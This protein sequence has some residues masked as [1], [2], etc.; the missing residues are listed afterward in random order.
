[1][2]RMGS[3]CVWGAVLACLAGSASA[4]TWGSLEV[5]DPI[6]PGATCAVSSPAS[7]G[8]YIYHW[9][10]KYEQVFWPLTDRQG[11]WFC[12][13]SG[14]TSFLHDFDDLEPEQVLR[15]RQFLS[16]H[17]QP[18]EGEIELPRLLDLLE[19]IYRLRNKGAEFDTRL[20]RVLAYWNET[21]M[22]NQLKADGYRR[23]ALAAMENALQSKL[24]PQRRWEYLLV[25]A[26]YR[27][28]FGDAAVAQGMLNILGN[29][30]K[31]NEDEELKDYADYLQALI[32][33]LDHIKPGGAFIPHEQ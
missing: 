21:E 4:T 10:S 1:M 28:E 33:D 31:A 14:F 30:L 3:G 25:S 2:G 16:V 17:Y 15:I 12:P 26:A 32:V 19:P 8:S 6:E 5:D 18:A 23:R 24:E 13:A 20:L 9:P 27:R 11:I 7:Y 22:G 29:E